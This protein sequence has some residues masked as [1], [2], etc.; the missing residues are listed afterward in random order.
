[1][2]LQHL[3]F[4]A[5]KL[6]TTIWNLEFKFGSSFHDH[7]CKN[8]FTIASQPFQNLEHRWVEHNRSEKTI[9]KYRFFNSNTIFVR[10]KPKHR[11]ICDQIEINNAPAF[12]NC[13]WII[14]HEKLC[15][16]DEIDSKCF[17]HTCT[18][19]SLRIVSMNLE[20]GARNLCG[21]RFCTVQCFTFVTSHL[22]NTARILTRDWMIATGI[23]NGFR[24]N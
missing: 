16:C 15:W 6:L 4:S 7:I 10:W 20:F 5:N 1:M 14:R 13:L 9:Q 24:L 12:C 21:R 23:W 2:I 18:L 22:G 19:M 8:I 17:T 3:L 11:W